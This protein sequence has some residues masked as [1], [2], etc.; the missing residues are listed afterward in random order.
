M[1]KVIVCTET[2]QLIV[3]TAGDEDISVIV[4]DKKVN[5]KVTDLE[6]TKT[7]TDEQ[8]AQGA[9]ELVSEPRAQLMEGLG[10]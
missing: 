9:D 7:P 5:I 8:Q 1:L 3:K 6:R 10:L 2:M 4:G